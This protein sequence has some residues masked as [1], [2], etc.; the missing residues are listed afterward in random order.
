VAQRGCN[1]HEAGA[2]GR[3]EERVRRQQGNTAS[4]PT[5]DSA[6]QQGRATN[7]LPDTR[8]FELVHKHTHAG[9]KT[10]GI[11]MR[12]AALSCDVRISPS[13][14]TGKVRSRGFQTASAVIP[15]PQKLT[16]GMSLG[17]AWRTSR[18]RRRWVPGA[19]ALRLRRVALCL[20]QI[21]GPKR[22]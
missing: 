15:N 6:V 4:A 16:Q 18:A 3:H 11:C 14:G 22:A 2:R 1:T 7:T 13:G 8:C 10:T 5:R 17:V 12:G 21:V 19:L 20:R 9:Y